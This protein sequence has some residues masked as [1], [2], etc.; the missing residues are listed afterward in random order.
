MI[1]RVKNAPTPSH[2]IGATVCW[3]TSEPLLR[4]GQKLTIMHTTRTGRGMD[5]GV[6]YRLEVNILYRDQEAGELRLNENGRVQLRT[7]AP[8]LC[9]AYS[10]NRAT[11]SWII[12]DEASG[13]TVDAD[14][15]TADRRKRP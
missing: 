12:I 15:I 3:V 10:K 5:K 14:M 4:P 6:Q 9:D 1:E 2:D 13:V 7:T 11:G 8:L